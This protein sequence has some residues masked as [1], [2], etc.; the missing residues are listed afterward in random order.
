MNPEEA[1]PSYG[2][3]RLLAALG[4]LLLVPA[5]GPTPIP[6]KRRELLR[7]WC[8]DF[9]LVRYDRF[10]SQT[11]ALHEAM[12]A[13]RDEP[14]K[15]TLARARDAWALARRPYKEA[16]VFAFGP[17]IEEPQRYAPKI[18]FW[19]V[20]AD[21]IEELLAGT[22]PIDAKRLGVTTKGMPAMEYL[23]FRDAT[24]EALRASPR[25]T[26]ALLAFRE[27]L[28]TQ[29]RGLRDAWAP[30]G[31]DFESE[32]VEAGTGSSTFDTLPMALSEV[33]NHMAFTIEAIRG[34][35]LAAGITSDGRPAPERLESPYSDR[36]VDD[37]LDNLRGIELLFFGDPQAGLGG[38]EGL[39]RAR[40]RS[41]S[42]P[43]SEHLRTSRAA[44]AALRPLTRAVADDPEGVDAA[45]ERLA[46]L[47]RVIQ[48]DVLGALSLSVRFSDNDGD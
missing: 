37:I 18:D 32:L 12:T 41:F 16:E 11:E 35:K 8:D 13:L 42:A 44:L 25:P 7:S 33:V 14:T 4:F 6:D 38:L 22:E 34:G 19:P 27:D 46:E 24:L 45:G 39:L 30:D 15:D 2:R 3:R 5:C 43:M 23:L 26:E 1:R 29:A 40:G 17:A 10:V 20:R 47:Q 21:D 9:L 28:I 36:S 31:G 48:V